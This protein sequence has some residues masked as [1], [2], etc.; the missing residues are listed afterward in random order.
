M[1]K[2]FINEFSVFDSIIKSISSDFMNLIEE[3]HKDLI[4]NIYILD[5]D[6]NDNIN[7]LELAKYIRQFDRI[8]KKLF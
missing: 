3:A 4:H 2:E 5:I 1:L 7:G 8:Y 6:L